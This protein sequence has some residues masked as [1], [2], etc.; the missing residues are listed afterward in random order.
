MSNAGK[1]R[2]RLLNLPRRFSQ[3]TPL[4]R[5]IV[6]SALLEMLLGVILWLDPERPLLWLLVIAVL[7]TLAAAALLLWRRSSHQRRV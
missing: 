7:C 1:L 2:T 6:V 4:D 5:F 3:A